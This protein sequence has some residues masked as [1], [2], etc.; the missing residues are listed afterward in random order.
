M[1]TDIEEF[2]P[3]DF[4][5]DNDAFTILVCAPRRTGKTVLIT[6]LVD[7]FQKHRKYDKAYLF[8]ETATAQTGVYQF[9]PDDHKYV[10][11]DEAVLEKIFKEQEVMKKKLEMGQI[12][13][14]VRV[15]IIADDIINTKEARGNV[16][17]KL[18]TNGRH[19]YIDVFALSQTMKGFHV[20]ARTNSDLIIVW[21]SLRQDDR[22]TIF[23][24]YMS[25]EDGS[26]SECKKRAIA[27]LNAISS[28]QYRCM[29]VEAW[30]SSY[31]KSLCDYITWYKANPKAKPKFIGDKHKEVKSHSINES[32]KI[33]DE[34]GKEKN[35][36]LRIKIKNSIKKI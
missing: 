31:S 11:L 36:N 15:L 32:S 12:N 26:K 14:P 17:N 4:I 35:L 16:F 20:K 28:E 22:E 18:F 6:D 24:D 23:E 21:R 27:L 2:S 33:Y 13:E 9:I 5:K 25:I 7:N 8:S 29:I 10:T 3:I 1:S 34:D 19:Y 30:K